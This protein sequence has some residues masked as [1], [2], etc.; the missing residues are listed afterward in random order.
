MLRQGRLFILLLCCFCSTPGV[1]AQ[2]C[3]WLETTENTT[4]D[5]IISDDSGY[6]VVAGRI[7]GNTTIASVSVTGPDNCY[8][9]K[10]D[11]NGTV[12]WVTQTTLNSSGGTDGCTFWDVVCDRNGNYYVTGA[13]KGSINF[14]NGVILNASANQLKR[15]LVAYNNAGVA[16]WVNEFHSTNGNGQFSTSL[17]GVETDRN[18]QLY[19]SLY[20]AGSLTYTGSA[21]TMTSTGPLDTDIAL[22]KYSPVGNLTWARRYGGTGNQYGGRACTL[23]SVGNIYLLGSSLGG[24]WSF[25]SQ[26]VNDSG[27][28]LM[29]FNSAGD[30]LNYRIFGT[31]NIFGGLIS[32]FPDGRLVMLGHYTN[33]FNLGSGITLSK[34][35][36]AF[37]NTYVAL[38]DTSFNC[39][40]A[41]KTNPVQNAE[42]TYISKPAIR[43]NSIFIGGRVSI[44]DLYFG[45][46]RIPVYGQTAGTAMMAKIDSLGNILWCFYTGCSTCSHRV[47]AVTANIHGEAFFSGFW[48]DTINVF[49]KQKFSGTGS[50]CGFTA[51]VSDYT[52]TR[53][54]VYQGPY[55]A[56]DSIRI[57]YTIRGI[58]ESG[59]EFIA[60]L[61]DS[62]GRFDSSYR[63]L[64]RLTGTTGGTITG[65]LPLFKVATSSEYR[66]RVVSTKPV[67]QSYYL[68]DTLQ[69]L[70]FSKDSA[71]AGEDITICKG[72]QAQLHTQ[73]GSLWQWSP[74]WFFPDPSDTARREAV[75]KPDTTM[76]YRI[77]ISDSIGC[78]VVD[79]DFVRIHVRPPLK[80]TLPQTVNF[81]LLRPAVIPAQVQG[82]DSMGYHYRWY[83]E[84]N[85]DAVLSTDSILSTAPFSS[86][87]YWVVIGDSCS[88]DLD[89]A[90]VIVKPSSGVQFAPITDTTICIGGTVPISPDFT[91]CD[92]SAVKF[93]WNQG[94]GTGF[95]KTLSPTVSTDYVVVARDTVDGTRDTL[96]FTI[97][98][99]PALSAGIDGD[100]L[101]CYGQAG[102]LNALASGG[103]TAYHYRWMADTGSGFFLVDTASSL[104]ITGTKNTGY[105]LVLEDGCPAGR[106]SAETEVKVADPLSLQLTSDTLVC[107]REPVTLFAMASGGNPAGYLVTWYDQNGVQ[108]DTGY[109]LERIP[110]QSRYYYALLEDGCTPGAD[111]V[112]VQLDVRDSLRLLPVTDST[113]CQGTEFGLNP[114]ASGGY[115]PGYFF[116]LEAIDGSYSDTGTGFLLSP[117]KTADYLLTLTDDCSVDTASL[118][119]HLDLL[120]SLHVEFDMKDSIC[121]GEQV[122]MDGRVSGGLTVSYNWTWYRNDTALSQNSLQ[123]QDAPGISSV[124]RLELE[125][126]C[127]DPA[128]DTSILTVLPAPKAVFS[129]SDSIG[130]LPVTVQFIDAS[131]NNDPAHNRW[132]IGADFF[133]GGAPTYT[134][135]KAGLYPVSLEVFNALR[136]S[137]KLELPEAVRVWPRPASGFVIDP[138]LGETEE[139]LQL[140]AIGQG[141]TIHYWNM[142]NGILLQS[143]GDA[144]QYSYTDSGVY[145]VTHIAVNQYGCRDSSVQEIGIFLRP[146]CAVPNA[147][148][149]NGD[150]RNEHFG[151]ECSG[152]STYSMRITDRWGEV[153]LECMDCY[154]DGTYQ[155][156]SVPGGVYYYRIDYRTPLGKRF[157]ALGSV[158]VIR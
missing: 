75:V 105:R 135:E 77:V 96:R 65:V 11:T 79:T 34:T 138:E 122:W 41:L 36:T 93:Y 155:G 158:M 128:A 106:D 61:S 5:A 46:T 28:L 58:Y 42:F 53:G 2:N 100:T 35:G 62:A 74:P 129:M 92:S 21:T 95:Q 115:A 119:F 37:F 149:P 56:G 32:A 114:Q 156:T 153:L 104:S 27:T 157:Y 67:V 142:G 19:I 97:W 139:V 80:V 26:T 25:G 24:V 54:N 123:W 59:N 134:F 81:C 68:K 12:I 98:V 103:D 4:A 132:Q 109:R 133:E 20:F 120:D 14:G 48:N 141:A 117:T 89:S 146:F 43:N 17:L 148:S 50:F 39:R 9:L 118:S 90:S 1:L 10:Y 66:I 88:S 52:I 45:S 49:N 18:N 82:G 94:L 112:G 85:P 33:T 136:C 47:N 15:F 87:R 152:I 63:E 73:G 86:R 101:L 154:W 76:E 121:S 108:A 110:G 51:K 113:L 13:S 6:V 125:D 71:D 145:T 22:F 107:F 102:T 55:C 72:Q 99:R 126:G 150:G 40:W 69:L 3:E 8:L 84:N 91:A 130:C 60:E 140:Q 64:G 29:K 127:S 131:Q 44:D 7:M 137:D 57:P 111:S 78:G 23:D 147:F 151:P 30:P 143:S 144:V 116:R 38:I 16:M 124:Y 70:I 83:W 31:G